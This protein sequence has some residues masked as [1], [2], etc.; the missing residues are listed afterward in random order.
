MRAFNWN[1]RFNNET[2]PRH[3]TPPGQ[4][5]PEYTFTDRMKARIRKLENHFGK[6]RTFFIIWVILSLPLIALMF[7][8]AYFHNTHNFMGARLRLVYARP[9]AVQMVDSDGNYAVFSSTLDTFQTRWS[10]EYMNKTINRT[11]RLSDPSSFTSG[12]VHIYTF[13]DGVSTLT[14]P[15]TF[16]MQSPPRDL[17][18]PFSDEFRLLHHMSELRT[19]ISTLEA[20]GFSMLAMLGLLMGLVQIM[21]A[22]EVWR[23]AHMFSVEGGHPTDLA[24]FRGILG[25]F[26]LIIGVYI[27]FPMIWFLF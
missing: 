19:S 23:F 27:L 20:I 11:P 7:P 17:P 12:L 21:Y 26:I 9:D 2:G 15:I 14:R 4:F 16:T 22:E 18:S 8:L 10:V 5:P 6:G 3:A 1:D 25:G 13:S 24:L